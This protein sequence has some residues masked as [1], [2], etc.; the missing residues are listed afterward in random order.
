MKLYS[1]YADWFRLLTPPSDYKREAAIH[2]KLL[3]KHAP[4]RPRTL[5]ELGSGGGHNASHLRRRF[6]MTLVD[7][8][9]A[10]LRASRRLNPGIE[11]LIGDMRTLRLRR[12]FDAVF[13]HDAIMHLTSERDLR[14]AVATA[15]AHL[16]PGGVALFA[17]DYVRDSFE[18]TVDSGS[19]KQGGREV[20]WIGWDVAGQ[21][22]LAYY[23][24][25]PKPGVMRGVVERFRFGLFTRATWMRV[26]RDAGFRPIRARGVGGRDAFIGCRR[27]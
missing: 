15:F 12:T 6:K 20:R 2:A 9:P 24:I 21:A 16:R 14:R 17:P 1:A 5:L 23:M 18:P 27:G 13:I 3:L 22:T 26:L 11:H 4:R 8:S 25:G 10:M 7:L 19:S